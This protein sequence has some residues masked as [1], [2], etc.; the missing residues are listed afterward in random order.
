MH[1]YLWPDYSNDL[2]HGGAF[3]ATEPF[4][5]DGN[6]VLLNLASVQILFRS[7]FIKSNVH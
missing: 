6:F 4:A 1:L 2:S 5:S 7:C 3:N